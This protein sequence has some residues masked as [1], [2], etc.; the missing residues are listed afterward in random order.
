MRKLLLASFLFL[1]A[2]TQALALDRVPFSP[3]LRV[4]ITRNTIQVIRFPYKVYEAFVDSSKGIQVQA[5]GKDLLIK[6]YPYYKK[7]AVIAVTLLDGKGNPHDCSIVA[8]PDRELPEV[9]EVYIPEREV[10]S[11]LRKKASRFERGMPYEELLVTLVRQ[12]MTGNYPDYYYVRKENKE[13]AIFKEIDIY[14]TEV[15]EGDK[16]LVLKGN[17]KNR[18]NRPIKID[19]TALSFLSRNYDVKAISIRKHLLEPDGVTT[20]VAVVGRN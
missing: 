17:V 8:V 14:L 1:G 5:Q 12:F 16:F 11:E 6:W 19:E 13:L 15:G 10:K 3:E 20:F 18:L 9:I 4:H 2:G 7:P